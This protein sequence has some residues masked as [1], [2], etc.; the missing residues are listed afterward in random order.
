MFSSSLGFPLINYLKYGLC[1][2]CDAIKSICTHTS[3]RGLADSH[4]RGA[5]DQADFTIAMYLIQG[6]MS[7]KITN[8][9]QTLPPGL[10]EQAGGK[11]PVGIMTHGTGNS[12]SL[13]PSLTGSFNTSA[14][15]APQLTGGA[16]ARLQ[17][18]TTGSEYGRMSMAIPP[19][20]HVTF[21]ATPAV[22]AL[23]ASAFGGA[24]QAWDVT[25]EEKARFDQFF[26]GLDTQRRG[27]IEG[28]IAVPFMLQ[29][30]LSGDVLALVWYALFVPYTRLKSENVFSGIL[31]TSTTT[32]G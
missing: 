16:R 4:D 31:L 29:S 7:G 30:K 20:P 32:A 18:Q 10:Y 27:Y 11:P 23:G 12:A 21:A 26:D 14:P 25:A 6:L 1:S 2:L 13:S 8:L 28:D 5:L 15:L 17:P 24:S 19:Q 9:P 3:Y 22:Q